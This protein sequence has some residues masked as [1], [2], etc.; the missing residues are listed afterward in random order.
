VRR[1]RAAAAILAAAALTPA[2]NGTPAAPSPPAVGRG[3]EPVPAAG[4]AAAVRPL[5]SRG[6][7]APAAARPVAW[8]EV[9]ADP[10][11]RAS[12]LSGRGPLPEDEGM[13]FVYP[14]DE[15]RAFWMKGCLHPLSAAFLDASGRVVATAEMDPPPEA[16]RE[17]PTVRYSSGDP[18]R[19]V[20][21]MAPGW[22]ERRGIRR[23]S[24]LDLSEVLADVV[25]R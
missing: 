7:G 8:V 1:G 23:G 2:C 11:S 12:G 10:E 16:E 5:A 6:G 21:E 9:A 19:Y 14:D 18:A 3:R 25:V 13:L 20:L 4:P 15:V 17:A 22:F 24:R